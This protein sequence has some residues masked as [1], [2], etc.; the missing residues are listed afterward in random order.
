MQG[1]GEGRTRDKAVVSS[2]SKG[3]TYVSSESKEER[4]E[5]TRWKKKN[6]KITTESFP[7]MTKG[8]NPPILSLC[9]STTVHTCSSMVLVSVQINEHKAPTAL[10]P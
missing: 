10:S 4:R 7:E 8:I 1:K 3:L 2:S 5:K 6:Q 9:I